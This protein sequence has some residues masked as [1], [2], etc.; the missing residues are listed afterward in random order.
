MTHGEG[1]WNNVVNTVSV[2]PLERNGTGVF[3]RSVSGL[4]LYIYMFI[5]QNLY[6]Y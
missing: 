1:V 5:D 3:W 6:N 4:L 2:C